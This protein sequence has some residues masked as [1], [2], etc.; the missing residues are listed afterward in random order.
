M[1]VKAGVR[2]LHQVHPWVL[3]AAI[4]YDL[5]RQAYGLG[6][7][8]IT[9]AMDDGDAIGRA[10]RADSAHPHGMALDLRT[11]DLDEH[12]ARM[13]AKVLVQLL[14]GKVAVILEEDHIHLQLTGWRDIVNT[15][16][17]ID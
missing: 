17:G 3:L 11:T 16:A 10:R 9:S 13:V 6:E 7:G 14:E 12:S 15:M 2:G 5:V 8:T 1:K 4:I